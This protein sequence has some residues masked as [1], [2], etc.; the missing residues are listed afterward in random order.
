MA[1]EITPYNHLTELAATGLLNWT[2]DPLKIAFVTSDYTFA[3]TH[4]TYGDISAHIASGTTD[5]TIPTPTV[6]RTGSIT[7]LGGTNITTDALTATF[8]RGIIY[9]DASPVNPDD[10]IILACI[11]FD[12][13]SGG[14]DITLTNMQFY[15]NW[16][17][18][19]IIRLGLSAD[20]CS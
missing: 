1:S 19:G 3:A 4:T 10:N 9:Q 13:T 20:I 8:R 6:S 18:D 15:I 17:G 14:Q 11:L 7:T 2:G 16:H 12:N 5:V